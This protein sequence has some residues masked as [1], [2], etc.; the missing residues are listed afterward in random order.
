MKELQMLDAFITSAFL[1]FSGGLQ[2]AY[3]FN[4]RERVFAIGAG[5]GGVICKQLGYPTLW[6]SCVVLLIPLVLMHE[7][8]V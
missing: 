8:K 2:D 3:T 7:R 1:A 5:L 6:I 4:T